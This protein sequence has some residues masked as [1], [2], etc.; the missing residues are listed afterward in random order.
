LS[1]LNQGGGL[2]V[3]EYFKSRRR[4]KYQLVSFLIKQHLFVFNLNGMKKE[5][6][7]TNKRLAPLKMFVLGQAQ[8][9]MITITK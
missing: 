8:A 2:N 5:N 1:I 6:E 9:K 4:I 7:P 3:I